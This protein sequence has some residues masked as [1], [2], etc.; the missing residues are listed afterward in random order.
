M[1]HTVYRD[2]L[3]LYYYLEHQL[4]EGEITEATFQSLSE[5]LMALK[6]EEK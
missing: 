5:A 2:W 6:P 3:R 4:Y 1:K